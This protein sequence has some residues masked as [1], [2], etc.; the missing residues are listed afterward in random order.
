LFFRISFRQIAWVAFIFALLLLV[1]MAVVAYRTTN[2]L[3]T[4]ENWVSHTQEVQARLEDIRADIIGAEFSRRGYTITNDESLLKEY[5]IALQDLAPEMDRL[6]HLMADNSGRQQQLENLQSLIN[7]SLTLQQGSVQARRS[8][9]ANLQD[10]IEITRQTAELSDETAALIESIEHSENQLLVQRQHDAERAYRHTIQVLAG[11]FGV[12]LFLLLL[13]FY[14]L[15]VEFGRHETTQN[16]AQQSRELLNAFF[17]SSS[18]GFGILDRDLRFTRVNQ[19]LAFMSGVEGAGLIG[20]SLDET[21]GRGLHAEEV[22]QTVIAGGKPILDCEI[23]RTKGRADS[24]PHFWSLNYFPIRDRKGNVAQVGVIAIDVTARRTAESAIRR[25]TARLLN[26]QDQER[27]RIAREIHD[28]LGQYLAGLKISLDLMANPNFARKDDL[29]PECSDLV[30]RCITETRTISHL[31]HPPLLDEAGFAS[32]ASWF[33]SGFSQRSGIPVTLD[34]PSGLPRM[35]NEVEIA[36]FRVLQESL[37]NVHR[38]SGSKS[39][40]ISLKIEDGHVTLLIQDHGHGI[41]AQRLR[42]MQEDGTQAGVGLAG[43]RERVRELGG[44]FDLQ[45]NDSGTAI[46]IIIPIVENSGRAMAV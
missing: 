32:A 27:R 23:S 24:E 46:S 16:I 29:L 8:G 36:L 12:V 17:S 26:L 19:V 45:S 21:L 31:L 3:V 25:L 10:D 15:N 2:L 41:S 5:R 30:Q 42:K 44:Q 28:S 14:A 13:E 43:M 33:V 6:R 40:E 39:A 18:L 22:A 34:L 4:S 7:R 38:H 35:P 20:K 1:I 11:T 9:R 37:T